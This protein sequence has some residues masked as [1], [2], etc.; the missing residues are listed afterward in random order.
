[1]SDGVK[2]SLLRCPECS[3]NLSGEKEGVFLYCGGGCGAGF[4]LDEKNELEKIPVYFARAVK[5]TQV[6][7]P[8]WAFDATLEVQ[9]RDTKA[10]IKSLLGS[11][12]GLI[13]L[14]KEKGTIRMYVSAYQGDLE[15][16]RPRALQLTYD[17]PELEFVERGK[18]DGLIV[19]QKDARKVADYLFLTSEI[20][21]S[22]MMRDLKY[23]LTLT[24]PIVILIGF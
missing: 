23:T 24:N 18:I 1:M 20:E 2:L 3:G 17:Q 11:S 5:N 6:Y 21:Q 15:S 7:F 8:F 22:D 13:K 12:G 16:P 14:F 10:S 19:S 4:Q 9:D